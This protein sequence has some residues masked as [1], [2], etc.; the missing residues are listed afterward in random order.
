MCA[1]FLFGTSTTASAHNSIVSSDPADG[2]MLAGAP[3]QITFPFD[4]SVPLDTLS[5]ELIDGSG[6]RT[7]LYEFAHGPSGD[8]EVVAT[9]PSLGAG[10]TTVR[11]RLLGPTGNPSPAEW[12][13]ASGLPRPRRRPRL[14][15]AD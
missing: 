13:S 11:W 1:V 2:A 3:A 5:I 15:P 10:E 9:L 12:A 4:K 7:E 14:P 8:T 6:I